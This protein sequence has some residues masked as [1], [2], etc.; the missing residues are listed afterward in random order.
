MIALWAQF[1]T[2]CASVCTP[3]PITVSIKTVFIPHRLTTIVNSLGGGEIGTR[4]K[5]QRTEISYYWKSKQKT[6]HN[7]L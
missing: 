6:L 3:L 5:L 2:F 7:D 1:C 4:Y